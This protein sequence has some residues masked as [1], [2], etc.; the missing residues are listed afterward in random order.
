MV[1]VEEILVRT[2]RAGPAAVAT[3]EGFLNF[4]A[5]MTLVDVTYD[6]A[7]EAARIRAKAGLRTPDALIIASAIVTGTGVLVTSDRSWWAALDL[8]AADVE[9]VIL[10]T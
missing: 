3:A 9:L 4:F 6:I 7:R 2:F 1:T 10:A 8:L 5:E